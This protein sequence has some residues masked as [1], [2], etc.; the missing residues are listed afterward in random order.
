MYYTYIPHCGTQDVLHEPV[1]A[2]ARS[3]L[4]RDSYTG[5]QKSTPRVKL[6][7]GAFSGTT[8]VATVESAELAETL[9]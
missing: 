7:V 8:P 4:K 1:P 9:D 5:G 3:S 2:T 6:S